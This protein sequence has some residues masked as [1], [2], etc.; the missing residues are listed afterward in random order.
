MA[1]IFTKKKIIAKRII[2]RDS[3]YLGDYKKDRSVHLFNHERARS[4]RVVGVPQ[5][6]SSGVYRRSVA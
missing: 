5:C 2:T 6:N 1:L 4:I 3:N